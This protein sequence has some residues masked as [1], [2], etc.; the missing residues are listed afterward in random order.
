VAV[1]EVE[2]TEMPLGGA[3]V[4][5]IAGQVATVVEAEVVEAAEVAAEA[6]EVAGE[7]APTAVPP[8][9]GHGRMARQQR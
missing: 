2:V 8:H 9:L 7:V 1:A 3:A 4:E 5:E 6:A